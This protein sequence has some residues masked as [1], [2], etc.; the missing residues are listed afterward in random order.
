MWLGKGA[1]LTHL[2][3][4]QPTPPMCAVRRQLSII[5]TDFKPENVMLLE[6][7]Q[8]R[9]WEMVVQQSTPAPAAAAAAGAAAIPGQLTKNQK[10]KA[11]RKA[12]KSGS[13]ATSSQGVSEGHPHTQQH[14]HTPSSVVQQVLTVAAVINA[15]SWQHLLHSTAT[16]L[17]SSNT[18]W[19]SYCAVGCR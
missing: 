15:A 9:H 3:P 5:H 17:L 8:P 10:K 2:N 14:S 7:L 12:K 18:L 13:A 1:M 16:L 11:K 4:T 6:T 19:G